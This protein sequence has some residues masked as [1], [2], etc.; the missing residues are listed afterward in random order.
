LAHSNKYHFEG[1]EMKT[2]RTLGDRLKLLREKRKMTISEVATQLQIPM[3][4]YKEWE[5]GRQI[6]GEPYLKLAR[7]YQV[8]IQ[9]ILTGEKPQ[10]Q[11]ILTQLEEFEDRIR[12]LRTD[13]ISLI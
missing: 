10:G 6:R 12:L 7:V 2:Q 9:E 8:S 11:H 4:T 1:V 3:S 5:S 13:V